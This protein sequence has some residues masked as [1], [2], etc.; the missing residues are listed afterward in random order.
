MKQIKQLAEYIEEEVNDAQKYAKKAICYK[1]KDKQLADMYYQ[2]AN[3]QLEHSNV[4]HKQV[5]R[6]I[7]SSKSDGSS[8]PIGMQAVWDWQHERIVECTSKIRVLLEMYTKN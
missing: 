6:I 2:L 8:A 3:Q 4:Q 1:Q 5:V 7:E